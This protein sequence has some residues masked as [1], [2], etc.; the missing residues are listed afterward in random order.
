MKRSGYSSGSGR[1]VIHAIRPV[2]P[3]DTHAGHDS[4][5]QLIAHGDRDCKIESLLACRITL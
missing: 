4:F 3:H 5:R 2:Q 1:Q